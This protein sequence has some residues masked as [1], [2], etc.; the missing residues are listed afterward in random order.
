[1]VETPLSQKLG[2]W[3]LYICIACGIVV[4]QLLP[5]QLSPIRL[6][7]ELRLGFPLSGQ[8]LPSLTASIRS[9]LTPDILLA[10]TCAWIMRRPDYVPVILVGV[11]FLLAD[12][13]LQRPPGLYAVIVILGTEFLRTRAF[14]LR[15][16]F[17]IAEYLTVA[18]VIYMI[19]LLYFFACSITMIVRPDF[20][21]LFIQSM[22]T[23][24]LYPLVT[25]VS[26]AVF[27]IYHIG[28]GGGDE[29][30]GRL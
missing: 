14:E 16:G 2:Y 21:L 27:G 7:S 30:R 29:A 11:I 4:I 22:T 17:F 9:W 5:L 18:A 25:F 6:F 12:L 24:A 15:N 23:V 28:P 26:R 8:S 10:I 3:L 19:G 1:M 13:L 20:L